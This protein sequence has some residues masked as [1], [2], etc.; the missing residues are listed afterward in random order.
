MRRHAGLLLAL[1]LAACGS[2]EDALDPPTTGSMQVA[3]T[4]LPDS[5]AAAITVTGPGGFA[6]AVTAA[7]NLDDLAPGTY[8]VT[9]AAV[10]A[11]ATVFE[12]SVASQSLQVIAGGPRAVA[13]VTYVSAA[14]R[15]AVLVSGLPSGASASVSVSGPGSFARSLAVA[16]TLEGLAPGTYTVSS[17]NVTGGATTYQPTPAS[18]QVSVASGALATASVAYTGSTPPSLDLSIDGMYVVQ[19][20]QSYGDTVPLVA[21]RDAV[22]RVFARAN[23]PN[24]VAPA[25]RL[26]LY[27]GASATPVQTWTVAATR[28]AVPTTIREDSLA[29]SWNQR[30]PGAL[31]QPGARLLADVDP[32]D[33]VAESDEANNAFPASGTAKT[34]D[35][36][37]V[38]PFTIRFVPVRMAGNNATGNVSSA[39]RAQFLAT[40]AKLY[41]VAAINS[42]VRSSV[43]TTTTTDTLQPNNANGA[44]GAVLS[45]VAALR[46]SDGFTGYYYGVVRAGYGSGTAGIG[47]VPG[48]TAVGWD[49][50]P[51]GDGVA[52][53]E[54]GHNLS[55]SHAPCGG[56]GGADP[57]FPYAGGVA[58]IYGLD[59]ASMTLKLPSLT[60][61]MGY[62]NN[63]WISDY[64]FL[65]ALNYRQGNAAAIVMSSRAEPALLVWG[66]IV[67]G[68]VMLEPAFEITAPARLPSGRGA[69]T[70]EALDAAGRP[71][72]AASFDGERVADLG[73]DERHFAF[74]VPLARMGAG[75]ARLQVRGGFAASVRE[76]R[77]ALAAGA[78][79]DAAA[80]RQLQPAPAAAASREGG[81]AV[82]LRWN[83]ADYP[84]ALVRD[85]ATGDILSF[86]RGGDAALVSGATSLDI[87]FSD[88]VRSRKERAT[89]R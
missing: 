80:L 67:N 32:A 3:I 26:R 15:L 43:Y 82:R 30:V 20:V 65:K 58:G 16:D 23:A 78:Q 62:C 53:H 5:T 68:V 89:V 48:R 70:L 35:V 29:W 87:T 14:G 59:V 37:T 51:S 54:L 38:N 66:R 55:L 6:R 28:P 52:A 9:A 19:A 41:P 64:H 56:A 18:Q 50:L 46:A 74:V 12:P 84:M 34:L 45:E 61:L 77:A 11:A 22:V 24:S 7:A 81:E 39:N 76:S 49:R 86:A 8:T 10:T 25:V 60:D 1:A 79:A 21:G 33:A 75:V 88:G 40:F 85:A 2:T 42:D 47:Y 71:L 63:T 17:A 4:G 69:F 83:A 13:T 27:Q 57:N 36:R 73:E 72:Y 31:L 44:W